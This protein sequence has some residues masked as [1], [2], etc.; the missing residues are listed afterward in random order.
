MRGRVFWSLVHR[1]RHAP[2]ISGARAFWVT[3]LGTSRR[4]AQEWVWVSSASVACLAP[5]RG[6]TE[7]V[8]KEL[9][10]L[11]QGVVHGPVAVDVDR[12]AEEA[13]FLE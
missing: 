6:L 7:K 10:P 8:V 13:P 9:L 3:S 1:R 11:E 5:T 4:P 2:P 12:A